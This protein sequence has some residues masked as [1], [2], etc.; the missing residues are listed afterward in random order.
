MIACLHTETCVINSSAL[1][2][3]PYGSV[4][5]SVFSFSFD[6][7]TLLV[8]KRAVLQHCSYVNEQCCSKTKT[9]TLG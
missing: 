8:C 6:G 5:G 3:I 7:K 4:S 1:K 2:C 9:I